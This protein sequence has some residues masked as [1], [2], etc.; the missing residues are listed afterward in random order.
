[1]SGLVINAAEW[2]CSRAKATLT[3]FL[4][5]G[6]WGHVSHV[7]RYRQIFVRT[8][9]WL[10]AVTLENILMLKSIRYLISSNKWHNW[11]HIPI[12]YSAEK[13]L[14]LELSLL[15]SSPFFFHRPT[16]TPEE[17]RRCYYKNQKNTYY[18]TCCIFF[19]LC[20]A[21]VRNSRIKLQ[22]FLQEVP[23]TS[24]MALNYYYNQNANE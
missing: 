24:Y 11:W 13:N 20:I 2:Y 16:A 14:W 19:F 1:M 21:N 22:Y 17:P 6:L 8:F 10:L 5:M 7:A 4:V 18:F 12:S 23:M 15:A 9:D 3:I